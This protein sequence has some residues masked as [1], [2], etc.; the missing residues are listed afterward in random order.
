MADSSWI[1]CN[2][3][4]NELWKYSRKI[5]KIYA[6]SRK[7]HLFSYV[8]LESEMSK[9]NIKNTKNSLLWEEKQHSTMAGLKWVLIELKSH[10]FPFT[11]KKGI[12]C[13]SNVISFQYSVTVVSTTQKKSLTD[14]LK[15]DKKITCVHLGLQVTHIKNFKAIDQC[16]PAIF[17]TLFS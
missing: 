4:W 3:T 13:K 16:F 15:T 7:N 10:N 9:Q 6:H 8:P 5:A 2:E 11:I 14:G 1:G 17:S 12:L